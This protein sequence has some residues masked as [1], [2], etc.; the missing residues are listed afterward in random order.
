M[1]NVLTSLKLTSMD[2]I[3]EINAL[4]RP[5]TMEHIPIYIKRKH[6]KERI[7]YIHD[8]LEA[9]LKQTYGVLVYQEQIM[10]IVHEFAG[11]S[12]GEA[13]ILRRAISKKNRQL[14]EEQKTTFING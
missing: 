5:G 2:D 14:I 1:K 13:D 10:Q 12:L 3:V 11:L 7:T 6:G 8:D 4:Y 9:I